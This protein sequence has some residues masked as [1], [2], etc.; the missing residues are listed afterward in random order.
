MLIQI[1]YYVGFSY[2]IAHFRQML[3]KLF[4]IVMVNRC[5]VQFRSADSVLNWGSVDFLFRT[6][7][8]VQCLL[9]RERQR[10]LV[11]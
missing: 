3:S 9:R 10:V 7:F 6:L 1:K 11:T 2:K 8:G 5:G 4:F